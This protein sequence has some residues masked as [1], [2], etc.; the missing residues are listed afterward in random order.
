MDARESWQG[1]NE[2]SGAVVGCVED[3]DSRISPMSQPESI[4][5]Q[6]PFTRKIVIQ[7]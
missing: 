3:Y 5:H 7:S 2:G 6:F 4:E 1:S